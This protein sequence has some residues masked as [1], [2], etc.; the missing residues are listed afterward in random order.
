M[1][2]TPRHRPGF[3]GTPTDIQRMTMQKPNIDAVDSNLAALEDLARQVED[4]LIELHQRE[5]S[6]TAVRSVPGTDEDVLRSR[7]RRLS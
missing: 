5:R 7:Y 3:T 2:H 6:L 4:E 1:Y